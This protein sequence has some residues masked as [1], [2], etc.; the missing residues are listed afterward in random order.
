MI[1]Y[2][3]TKQN[4]TTRISFYWT[5]TIWRTAY[6]VSN[7]PCSNGVL[8]YYDSPHA[9]ALFNPIHANISEP[10]L[11]T[12][13][14]RAERG[15]DGLK[16]WCKSARILEKI[17]LPDITTEQR[18][19]FAIRCA[20]RVV[21]TGTNW[22]LWATDWLSGSC[23][24]AHAAA[25]AAAAAQAAYVAGAGAAVY[26]AAA[27]QAADAALSAR[28]SRYAAHAA[29]EAARATASASDVARELINSVIAET[30]KLKS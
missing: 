11:W 19:E 13:E 18:V 28:A 8:H 5:P 21:Y 2:K 23:R 14:T 26:A 24:N 12:L 9:A 29:A 25:Y 15:H 16:G 22:H 27:A 6:G 7:Y 20:Q 1:R 4:L 17:S 30:F 3:L 10:L